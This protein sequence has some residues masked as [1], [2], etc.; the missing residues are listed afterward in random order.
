MNTSYGRHAIER[1]KTSLDGDYLTGTTMTAHD[2][3]S[4]GPSEQDRLRAEECRVG[5]ARDDYGALATQERERA[6]AER[7]PAT[8][9]HNSVTAN[10][11]PG[12][13]P[14]PMPGEKP[15][16]VAAVAPKAKPVVLDE[17]PKIAPFLTI[18][19]EQSDTKIAYSD[20]GAGGKFSEDGA[21]T[22][23]PDAPKRTITLSSAPKGSTD[24]F[25]AI[26][27]MVAHPDHPTLAIHASA[28]VPKSGVTLRGPTA[29]E[30]EAA[31]VASDGSAR[32]TNPPAKTWS[33]T[34]TPTPAIDSCSFGA[35]Y[36]SDPSVG[37][38]HGGG[39][40]PTP[41][42]READAMAEIAGLLKP[43]NQ[44]ARGRV[45]DWAVG[46]FHPIAKEKP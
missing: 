3:V 8:K 14:L 12:K 15:K 20:G 32:F 6:R 42:D 27:P 16:A 30:I 34:L 9:Y 38:G 44:A 7:G 18:R 43:L 24:A 23:A 26:P 46:R 22:P 31:T 10:D 2:I 19:P 37:I 17:P 13:K 39:S 5:L 40:K 4:T 11:E 25:P 1:V 45:L 29:A 28:E 21:Y 33:G 35:G 41:R 36:L